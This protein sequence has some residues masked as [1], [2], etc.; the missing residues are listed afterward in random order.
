MGGRARLESRLAGLSSW[1]RI[2]DY[3]LNYLNKSNA[4]DL[5][6]QSKMTARDIAQIKADNVILATGSTWRRDGVGSMNF[7]PRALAAPGLLVLT[8]DDILAGQKPQGRVVVYDDEHNYMASV[9]AEDLARAGANVTYVTP[10]PTLAPWT[11]NTLEQKLIIDRL[12]KLG[13]EI[14]VHQAL[15]ETASGCTR[16]TTTAIDYETLVFVGA[17]TPNTALWDAL[18]KDRP[19]Y[20]IGDG[21][22]PGTIQAAVLSGHRIAREILAGA[23]SEMNLDR[24]L[25]EF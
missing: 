22:V 7:V 5:Y 20:R 2:V 19:L 17:R 3:R 15:I 4:V 21:E 14:W 9:I 24:Q 12:T 23:P 6:L 1:R 8:P 18:P 25:I 16:F 10:M 13:C 11:E